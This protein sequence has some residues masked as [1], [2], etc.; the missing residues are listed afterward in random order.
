MSKPARKL[1]LGMADLEVGLHHI[2][3]GSLPLTGGCFITKTRP[4]R[5]WSISI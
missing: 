4:S 2:M 3:I 5:A 1:A